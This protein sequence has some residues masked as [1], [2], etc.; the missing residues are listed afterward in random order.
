MSELTLGEYKARIDAKYAGAPDNS[1]PEESKRKDH[2]L[3][4]GPNGEVDGV[5]TRRFA[6]SAAEAF[7]TFFER[8]KERYAASAEGWHIEVDDANGSRWAA[9]CDARTAVQS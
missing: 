8:K 1:M 7:D 3:L 5:M 9:S 4:V 6:K 2:W